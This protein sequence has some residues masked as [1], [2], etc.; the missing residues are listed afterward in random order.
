[1]IAIRVYD[2]MIDFITSAP[3]PEEIISFIPF[4]KITTTF[5]G[6]TVQA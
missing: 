1:M 5:G 3:R 6:F 4:R 2:E